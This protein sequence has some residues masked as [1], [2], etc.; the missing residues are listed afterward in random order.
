MMA[1]LSFVSIIPLV[2]K[3]MG[4]LGFAWLFLF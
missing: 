4:I 3:K 2:F 1:Q